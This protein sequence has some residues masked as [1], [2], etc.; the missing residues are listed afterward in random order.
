MGQHLL[1]DPSATLDATVTADK[2]YLDASIDPKKRGSIVGNNPPPKVE[3]FPKKKTVPS[4]PSNLTAPPED[5][6]ATM[7]QVVS[8]HQPKSVKKPSYMT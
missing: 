5:K 1:K 6:T 3:F 4:I 7:N 8:P 2:I